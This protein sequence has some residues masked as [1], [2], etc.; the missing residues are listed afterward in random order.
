M[1]FATI[2]CILSPQYNTYFLTVEYALPLN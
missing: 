1:Y 2:V